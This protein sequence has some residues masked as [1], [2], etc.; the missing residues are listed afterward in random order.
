MFLI[1]CSKFGLLAGGFQNLIGHNV[2]VS[3]LCS[4]NVK[5]TSITTST[6]GE[7]W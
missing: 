6:S 3:V 1:S 4:I 7:F 2:P 5:C